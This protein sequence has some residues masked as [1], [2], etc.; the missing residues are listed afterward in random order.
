MPC[1][2]RMS[3]AVKTSYNTRL[4]LLS[5]PHTRPHIQVLDNTSYTLNYT[6]VYIFCQHLIHTQLCTTYTPTRMYTQRHVYVWL[7]I[8]TAQIKTQ[9]QT[10]TE[11]YTPAAP[12]LWRKIPALVVSPLD[13]DLSRDCERELPPAPRPLLPGSDHAEGE[14]DGCV[15]RMLREWW[16]DSS[17][18]DLYSLSRERA[19]SLRGPR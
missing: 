2:S 5:R 1:L 6:L 3:C 7:S 17:R 18:A 9:T 11:A 10:D 4:H 16:S 14:R 12:D 8:Y 19:R 15:R 13:R